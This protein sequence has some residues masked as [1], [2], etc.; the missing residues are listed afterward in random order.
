MRLHLYIIVSRLFAKV[1]FISHKCRVYKR[2]FRINLESYV[3]IREKFAFIRNSYGF[4][5]GRFAFFSLYREIF[6]FIRKKKKC[7]TNVSSI[8][9]IV[10]KNR[11]YG[12]TKLRL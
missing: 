6:R 3:F 1:Q 12:V 8:A 2:R 11:V 10:P 4:I 9:F 7:P 5:R